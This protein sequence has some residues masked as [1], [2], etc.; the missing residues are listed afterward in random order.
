MI[1]IFKEQI[2]STKLQVPNLP[3]D[4]IYRKRLIDLLNKNINKPVTLVSAGGGF[5]KS[6]LISNWIRESGYKYTW[7]SLDENDNDVRIFLTYFVT[8]V[9][10]LFP[11]FGKTIQTL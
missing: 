7:L 11:H 4:V 8:A 6:T 3:N 1:D 9:H 2:L 5:G 10:K